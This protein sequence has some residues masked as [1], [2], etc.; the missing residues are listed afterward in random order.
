VIAELAEVDAVDADRKDGLRRCETDE[1]VGLRAQSFCGLGLSDRYGEDQRLV[2]PS[3]ARMLA[4]VAMPSS[5]TIKVRP[6]SEHQI[7]WRLEG[8]PISPPPER[9][10]SMTESENLH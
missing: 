2:P 4:P 7:E 3:A 5:T 1:L 8:L 9:R 6:S 10:P